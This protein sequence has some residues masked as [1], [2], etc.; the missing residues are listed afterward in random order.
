MRVHFHINF[1]FSQKIA[2]KSEMFQKSSFFRFLGSNLIEKSKLKFWLRFSK[3][4]GILL[5][6]D[7]NLHS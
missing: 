3:V 5:K 6:F 4:D 7:E 1:W 2:S